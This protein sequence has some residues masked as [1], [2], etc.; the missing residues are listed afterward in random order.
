MHLAAGKMVSETDIPNEIVYE[1]GK[2]GPAAWLISL[3][4]ATNTMGIA[5]NL[6]R[7]GARAP[8]DIQ[9]RQ[10]VPGTGEETLLI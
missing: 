10:S 8:E 3:S 1:Q 2:G 9:S 7:E 4:R 6:V 5:V